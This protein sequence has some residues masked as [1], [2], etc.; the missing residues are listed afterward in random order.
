[1]E[2]LLLNGRVQKDAVQIRRANNFQ[3]I[4]NKRNEE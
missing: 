3:E 4:E 1:M 2:V